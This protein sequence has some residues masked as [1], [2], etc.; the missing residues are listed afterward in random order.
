MLQERPAARDE[1]DELLARTKAQMAQ[2]QEPLEL[3]ERLAQ[4]ASAQRPGA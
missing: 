4:E 3:T 1:P 2:A